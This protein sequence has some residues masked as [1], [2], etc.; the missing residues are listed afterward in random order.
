ML[1][2]PGASPSPT[3]IKRGRSKKAES[4]PTLVSVTASGEMLP[5]PL[6]GV[7]QQQTPMPLRY[8]SDE[9]WTDKKPPKKRTPSS[10]QRAPKKMV[11]RGKEEAKEGEKTYS[12]YFH[13]EP[14]LV[15]WR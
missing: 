3:P 4:T 14:N 7:E 5:M 11:R 2:T 12:F 8:D 15:R 9:E 13:S 1:G 6:V 10:T